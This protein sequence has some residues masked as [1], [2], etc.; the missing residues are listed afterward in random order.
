MTN[1]R[2][3]L[4]VPREMAGSGEATASNKWRKGVT[5]YLANDLAV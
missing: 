2:P 5:N 3:T 1:A 4:P